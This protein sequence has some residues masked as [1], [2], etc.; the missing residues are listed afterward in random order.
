MERSRGCNGREGS[1]VIWAEGYAAAFDDAVRLVESMGGDGFS[2]LSSPVLMHLKARLR[3][4]RTSER[5]GV[6]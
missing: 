6:A 2:N 4:L 5:Q 1:G 3:E